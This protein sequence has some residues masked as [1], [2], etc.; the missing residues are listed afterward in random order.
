VPRRENLR[1]VA[2]VAH[3]DHG[4]TTLVDAMLRQ[5]GIFK[6]HESL[7]ERVM[8]SM[9]LERERGITIMAKNT[10]VSYRGVR[11]NIVDTP[12]HA[13]FG[14][15]VERTLL[16]VDGILL[17][18]DA[19]EG[20]LPQTRFILQKA[21]ALQLP[22]VVVINKIDRSDARPEEVL[23]EIYD[24]FINLGAHDHQ[25]EFP[26]IYTVSREGTATMDLK[27]PGKDLEPLFEAILKHLPGPEHELDAPLQLRVNHLDYNDYVGRLA[28]GRVHAGRCRAGQTVVV[29]GRDGK[30]TTAKITHAYT[31]VG[32]RRVDIEEVLAGDIVCVSGTEP[33]IGDTLCEP[34][35]PAPLPRIHVDEPTLAMVFGVNDGPLAGKDGKYVTS[36]HLRDRLFKEARNNVAIRVDET[37]TPDRFKVVARGEL[38]LAIIIETMR[39][40]GYEMTVSRPEAVI[41]EIEGKPHEPVEI[42]ILDIPDVSLGPINESLAR[43]RAHMLHMEGPSGGRVRLEHRVPTRGLIGFR[44]EMLT[45]TRGLGIMNTIFDGWTPFLGDIQGRASGAILADRL[46]MTT[47]YAI[48]NLQPRGQMFVGP[49]T[50][51][52]EGMVV[53]EHSREND[54][55][56]NICREKKLTNIRAAGRDENVILSPPRVLS[57]EQALVFI[58]SDELVEITPASMRLRK[59]TL[60]ANMRARDRRPRP[61]E[62]EGD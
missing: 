34:E 9:A 59:R 27:V 60:P 3:V 62:D 43:R 24:L 29:C 32:L 35:R 52:Y 13:D 30:L 39:R 16:M 7:T 8:D 10:G 4:K 1:N 54:I 19:A 48:F 40:E 20:P 56:V 5:S 61:E 44:G 38:Q 31:Y 11:I 58:D 14:G 42:V 36:R 46:G 45:T 37:E 55:D 15:E 33:E 17:L 41:R 53:G 26:V 25:I 22:V 6:A 12:G 18:V 23:H 21:L 49:G 51:V 47:P 2:I 28:I 57:L 50:Q